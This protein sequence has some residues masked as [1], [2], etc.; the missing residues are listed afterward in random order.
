MAKGRWFKTPDG[1]TKHYRNCLLTCEVRTKWDGYVVL[2]RE[3]LRW[4]TLPASS[5]ASGKKI[6]DEQAKKHHCGGGRK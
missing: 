4:W 6:A 2:C 3:G 1:V 5:I